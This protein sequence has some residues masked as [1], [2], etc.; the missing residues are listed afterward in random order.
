MRVVIDS[1][2][3]FSVVVSGAKSKV[4]DIIKKYNLE[5]FTP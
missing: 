4:F 5:L 1:S 3:L 2:Q